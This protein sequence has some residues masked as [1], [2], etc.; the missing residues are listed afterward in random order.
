MIIAKLLAT[1]YVMSR[2]FSGNAIIMYKNRIRVTDGECLFG[3]VVYSIMFGT[4]YTQFTSPI[5][6]RAIPSL[7]ILLSDIEK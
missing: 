4:V 3:M 7:E 2:V 1:K 6:D 5:M